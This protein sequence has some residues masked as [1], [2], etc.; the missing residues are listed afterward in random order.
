MN[1]TQLVEQVRLEL[2][3]R[4]ERGTLSVSLLARQTGLGQ[5]HLS[6]FLHGRRGVKGE[7]LDRILA[8]Q[9]MTVEDLIPSQREARGAFLSGQIGR[10][11]MLPVVTPDA[12][13]FEQYIRVSRGRE[14]APFEVAMV[15]GMR[16]RCPPGRK[17]W[18]R[19]VVVRLSAADAEGMGPVM[20]ARSL[21]VVDRHYTSLTA[22][23]VGKPTLYAVQSE[24]GLVVRYAAYAASRLVLRPVQLGAAMRVIAVGSREEARDRVVGRVVLVVNAT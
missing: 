5:A 17:A 4:I 8:A 14:M 21:V 19:F 9:R 2:Q 13:M 3:R 11:V 18:E 23:E 15:S 1:F 22:Y 10:T 16:P 7:T 20:E 24:D 12:A 6:N